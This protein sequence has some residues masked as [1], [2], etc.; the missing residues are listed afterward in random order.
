MAGNSKPAGETARA[1]ERVYTYEEVRAMLAEKAR[2]GFRD[3]VKALL[4][5]H[6]VERL[7]E[8][9]E[10]ETLAA[11]AAEASAIQGN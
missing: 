1:S 5:G 10:P 4:T 8:V 9:R 7:S 11:L 3:S 6:G 2:A